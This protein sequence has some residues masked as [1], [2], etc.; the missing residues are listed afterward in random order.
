MTPD[1]NVLLAAARSDHPNHASA[2]VW[3][4]GALEAATRGQPLVFL[5]MVVASVLRIVTSARIFEQPSTIAEAIGWM[6]KLLD[7][8]GVQLADLGPEW[9]LLRQLS[10]DKRLVGHALPDAWIAAATLH[11]GEHLV[12]FDRDFRKLLPRSRLTLLR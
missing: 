7:R 3:C 12:T 10:L 11:L 9:P 6:D 8:P 5:P 2:H 4:T 1:V